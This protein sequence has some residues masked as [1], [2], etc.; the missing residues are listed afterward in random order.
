MA[1][2]AIEVGSVVLF[3]QGWSIAELG[4]LIIAGVGL[5]VAGVVKGASGLGYSS[6]ALPFLTAAVG[7]KTAIVLVVIPAMVS[8][9]AVTWS[10]GHFT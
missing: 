1:L 3:V 9:I 4:F 2:S 8:N 7:L 5:F 6:C 10:A